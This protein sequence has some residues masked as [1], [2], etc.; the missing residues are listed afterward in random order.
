[1]K[2]YRPPIVCF[3]V[4]FSLTSLVYSQSSQLK[5][6]AVLDLDT[7]GAISPTEAGTLTNRLRSMLVRTHKLNVLER[8]KMEEILRE[9]GLQQAGCTSTECMVEAGKMLSVELMVGGSVGKIGR[10]Y[11]VDILLIDVES[12]RIMKSL[13]RDYRGEIEGLLDLM[14]PIAEQLA[15]FVET[16]AV[17]MLNSGSLTVATD[18]APADIFLNENTLGKSPLTID[19][20][21]PG[22]YRLRLVADG[23]APVEDRVV[24]EKGKASEYIVTLKKLV[25][26]QIASTPSA[27]ALFING[28]PVGETPYSQQYIAGTRLDIKI[29][30]DNYLDWT[31]QE[32]VSRD[33]TITARLDFYGGS[34]AVTTTP[35]QAEVFL[36]DHRLG[37]SPLR[38]DNIAAGE[39]LLKI[40]AEGYAPVEEKVAIDVG[41]V[42]ERS[43]PL[44]KLCTVSITSTPPGAQVLIDNEP[45]GATPFRYQV[46]AGTKLSV[47]LRQQKYRDW[48]QEYAV[49]S[50]TEITAELKKKRSPWLWLGGSAV[51]AGGGAAAYVLLQKEQEKGPAGSTG[52]PRPPGRP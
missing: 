50:D 13:S 3:L 37:F 36:D 42:V 35:P 11:T 16:A 29:K 45:V 43:Y 32:I 28:L 52:F 10:L 33:T 49:T 20:L 31:R 21:L 44:V 40:V 9:V 30:M 12:S 23:Y 51:L 48:Q 22:E 39:H 5:S 47:T 1:M 26:V 4:L 15:A 8:G 24:I 34:L 46:T 2:K 14:G 6:I 25:T 19:N 27:A 17:K 7:R 18:P 38:Q 41:K